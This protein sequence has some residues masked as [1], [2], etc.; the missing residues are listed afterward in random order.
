MTKFRK[1]AR[2]RECMVRLPGICCG[3]PATT[4]LAHLRIAGYCGTGLKPDDVAFGAWACAR[5]HDACDGRLRTD[6]SHD[7]LQ[8]A[9]A[10]GVC[11]T[12]AH[13]RQEGVL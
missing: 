9:H 12:V 8:Q 7:E 11:R 4:V 3:D 1:L 10:I 6:F 2:G 5:C 13:L